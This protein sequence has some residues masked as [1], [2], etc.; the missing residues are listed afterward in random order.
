M[1]KDN[2]STQAAAYSAY[3][4][5]YPT[6]FAE[7]LAALAPARDLVWDCATGN[8]QLAALLAPHFKRV[9]ATDLSEKQL[10]HAAQAP[11]IE[12]RLEHA[13]QTSLPDAACDMITVAQAAHW[14]DL[15]RFY[16]EARR[17]LRPGGVIAV[18]GYSLF[19]TDFKAIDAAI[20]HFYH[21]VVG[22]YWDPERDY[23]DQKYRTLPFPFAPE[24]E[25]PAHEMGLRWSR[26]Q[27]LGYLRSWSAV[28]HYMRRHGVDPVAAFE[29]K[30]RAV[31]P[32]AD[33]IAVHWPILTRI[34]RVG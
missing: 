29:E 21:D 7:A 23:L 32:A 6:A 3:R 1:A 20:D 13:E 19:E 8:G 18:I 34:A 2:F 26:E 28:Q 24:I 17:V 16:A 27:L 15:D 22:P 25:F 5:V 9:V 11:N 4:P 33:E 12:Y 31:W 14:F 10:Q 30:I